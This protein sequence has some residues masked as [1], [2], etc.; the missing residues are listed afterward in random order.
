MEDNSPAASPDGPKVAADSYSTSP[1]R[2]NVYS[3]FTRFNFT[4]GPNS[5]QYCYSKIALSMST[6]HGFTWSTP[7][8]VSGSNKNLCVLGNHFDPSQSAR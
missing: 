3:S 7:Q 5:D 6:D 8:Q 1:N 4:C 2:D